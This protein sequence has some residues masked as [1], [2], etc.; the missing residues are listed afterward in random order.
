MPW[1]P[2]IPKPLWEPGKGG[3][4]RESKG[5]IEEKRGRKKEGS[6]LGHWFLPHRLPHLLEVLLKL[7][8]SLMGKRRMLVNLAQGLRVALGAVGGRETVSVGQG[9]SDIRGTEEK[10]NC[11]YE[12]A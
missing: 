3:G 4:R 10:G 1:A 6:W 8:K 9:R 11:A 12:K 2:S 5:E 7:R